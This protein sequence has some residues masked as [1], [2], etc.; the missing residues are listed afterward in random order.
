MPWTWGTGTGHCSLGTPLPPLSPGDTGVEQLWLCMNWAKAPHGAL[1]FPLSPA[2]G[3]PRQH[4]SSTSSPPCPLPVG[5]SGM[6]GG[7]CAGSSALSP[8]EGALPQPQGSA[9]AGPGGDNGSPDTT[10][11]GPS[12]DPPGTLQRLLSPRIGSS[13]GATATP[14]PRDSPA[15]AGDAPR[16]TPG[17]SVPL[18]LHFS[19]SCPGANDPLH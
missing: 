4:P 14:K 10:T 2:L 15:P 6:S 3:Q 19:L 9:S 11:Q 16:E 1:P 7:F 12:R 13:G 17:L 18:D 8:R 5:R